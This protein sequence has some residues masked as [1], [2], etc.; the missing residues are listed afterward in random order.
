MSFDITGWEVTII[1]FQNANV[2]DKDNEN[3]ASNKA[4]ILRKTPLQGV[5]SYTY[6]GIF[7]DRNEATDRDIKI[8]EILKQD[9]K[10]NRSSFHSTAPGP[11]QQNITRQIMQYIICLLCSHFISPIKHF[12]FEYYNVRCLIMV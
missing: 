1:K 7:V 5:E 8:R 4:N 2:K 9:H 6:L 12:V 3:K 10:K 11:I